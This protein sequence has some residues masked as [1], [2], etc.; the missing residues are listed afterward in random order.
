MNSVHGELPSYFEQATSRKL[1]IEVAS[2]KGIM[3]LQPNR[4]VMFCFFF[5]RLGFTDEIYM[6]KFFQIVGLTHCDFSRGYVTFLK[7]QQLMKWLGFFKP[8]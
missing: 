1:N 4:L 5:Y 7:K 6:K 2:I 3:Y 8:K